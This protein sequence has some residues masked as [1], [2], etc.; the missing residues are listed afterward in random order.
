MR[1]LIRKARRL[2]QAETQIIRCNVEVRRV[3]TAIVDEERHFAK[4][5]DNLKM[6]GDIVYHA[7]YEHAELRRRVNLHVLGWINRTYSLAGFTGN[8]NPGVRKGTKNTPAIATL[9]TVVE[10]TDVDDVDDEETGELSDDDEAVANVDR[11]VDY[12]DSV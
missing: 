9:H 5:L 3:H 4:V 1:T 7:V 12:V 11:V 6:T 2:A 10:P 8:A